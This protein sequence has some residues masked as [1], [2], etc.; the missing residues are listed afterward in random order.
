MPFGTEKASLLGAGAS[1]SIKMYG[2]G[3]ANSGPDPVYNNTEVKIYSDADDASFES[4][5][6][7][8]KIVAILECGAENGVR[9]HPL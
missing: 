7:N 1:S 4:M 8:P 9:R 2:G 6:K 3:G 5:A